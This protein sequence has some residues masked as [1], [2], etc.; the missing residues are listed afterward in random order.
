MSQFSFSLIL[1][2]GSPTIS[3]ED[4]GALGNDLLSDTGDLFMDFFNLAISRRPLALG[5]GLKLNR[6]C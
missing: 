2:I 5:A 4:L 1:K 6:V 3:C